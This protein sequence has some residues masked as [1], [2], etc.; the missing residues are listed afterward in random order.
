MSATYKDAIGDTIGGGSGEASG[1]ETEDDSR[2]RDGEVSGDGS[3]DEDMVTPPPKAK[4]RKPRKNVDMTADE[5]R[6][7]VL[8]LYGTDKPVED[9][10]ILRS[11]GISVDETSDLNNVE[12]VELIERR[13]TSSSP[14]IRALV[15]TSQPK[16]FSL[17]KLANNEKF[18]FE[19]AQTIEFKLPSGKTGVATVTQDDL[20]VPK[21]GEYEFEVKDVG[22]VVA[23]DIT[24]ATPSSLFFNFGFGFIGTPNFRLINNFRG[25]KGKAGILVEPPP[26]P[27][28]SDGAPVEY[29]KLGIPFGPAKIETFEQ[30][31]FGDY[32][33]RVAD[34]FDRGQFF[35]DA[36]G[37]TVAKAKKTKVKAGVN[38]IALISPLRGGR[39]VVY[40]DESGG[41]DPV[42]V[43]VEA[44]QLVLVTADFASYE[45]SPVD[46]MGESE[47]NDDDDELPLKSAK[48]KLSLTWFFVSEDDETAFTSESLKKESTKKKKAAESK[49][50]NLQLANS[51]KMRVNSYAV[52]AK[53]AARFKQKILGQE[54]GGG[55]VSDLWKKAEKLG[56]SE[57]ES[58][59]SSQPQPEDEDFSSS[60][61]SSKRKRR[62]STGNDDEEEDE[63]LQRG[64]G[65]KSQKRD[66]K[67]KPAGGGS[68]LGAGIQDMQVD[69]DDE[70]FQ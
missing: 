51:F 47:D 40:A 28:V 2:L 62:E 53:E 45:N 6:R 54:E 26:I 46:G 69:D 5:F 14:A 70:Y 17:S 34:V 18:N 43:S 36:H 66:G 65:G 25:E 21:K 52:H 59:S 29:E 19:F 3:D 12:H 1:S 23:S 48:G 55:G 49:S 63:S 61:S 64:K 57:S 67:S 42:V 24:K 60:S 50:A 41:T 56:L 22:T 10:V 20:V 68:G 9:K 44:N 31:V 15:V 37:K 39:F 32:T 13:Q 4:K 30:G 8:V 38:R 27:D 58:G 33:A 16:E 35:K 11:L 7:G